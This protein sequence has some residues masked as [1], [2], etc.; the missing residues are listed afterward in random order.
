MKKIK[1]YWVFK[2]S[3]FAKFLRRK[4]LNVINCFAAKNHKS[5]GSLK[6]K[7]KNGILHDRLILG[8]IHV[9]LGGIIDTQQNLLDLLK[10]KDWLLKIYHDT[11][12]QSPVSNVKSISQLQNKN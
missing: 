2:P 6:F 11:V 12:Q 4:K 8:V 9:L 3:N 5:Y 10:K 7:L 1:N